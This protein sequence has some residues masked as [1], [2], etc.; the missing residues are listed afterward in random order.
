MND[1]MLTYKRSND[2][3]VI[4]Y[5]DSDFT[6]CVDVRKLT[7]NYLLFLLEE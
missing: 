7:L 3:E 6:E 4:R 5:W 2:L 1:Y